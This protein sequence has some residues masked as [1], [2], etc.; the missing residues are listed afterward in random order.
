MRNKTVLMVL[1]AILLSGG[2]MAMQKDDVKGSLDATA[3][4][5]R[6]MK[7][8]R[9]LTIGEE[10][11]LGH[12]I[13]REVF[14]KYGPRVRDHELNMYI[15]LVGKTVAAKSDRPDMNYHFAILKNQAANAF[16]TPGGYIF[17]TTGLID[18]LN[19]EAQFAALLG[20]EIAHV[21]KMHIVGTILRSSMIVNTTTPLDQDTEQLRKWAGI[22]SDILFKSGLDKNLE[23]EADMAAVSYATSAGYNADGL[24]E[25]LITLQASDGKNESVFSRT[26]PSLSD[27]MAR[28]KKMES[29]RE[30]PG[31]NLVDRFARW[32]DK[33]E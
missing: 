4:G 30:K 25:F 2:A 23:Y 3:S 15:N 11:A 13:A 18:R 28:L 17:V 32:V 31:R 12:E 22:A 33:T 6:S 7:A 29:P 20:H 14:L 16:A 8:T 9:P 26:H 5:V 1:S 27:R 24:L 10:Q 21:A 19:S